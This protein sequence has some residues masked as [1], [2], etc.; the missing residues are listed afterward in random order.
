ML[1]RS[2]KGT[3]TLLSSCLPPADP[4][5]IR[6]PDLPAPGEGVQLYSP[7]WTIPAKGEGEVC[8][9]SYY[10]FSAQVPA[11]LQFDCPDR[12]GGSARKCFAY[13]RI[14]LTQDP[15]SHHSILRLY[16]GAYPI[17]DP[18]FG[19]FTCHGG[20]QD[21]MACNPTGIGV[22]APAGADCGPRSGCAG[23]VVPAVACIGYGP[24]DLS[25]GASI[26]GADS[27]KAPQIL[28]STSP[29]YRSVYPD[30]VY[31][32]MPVAGIFVENS[33]A[34][35]TTTEQIGRASCRERV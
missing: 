29:F 2:V 30:G 32:V 23:T 15:N 11:E 1:F 25:E 9:P 7:P 12:W 4:Q 20:D 33:H 5:K 17:T 6:P 14:E 8:V 13:K 34:F 18:S 10:D 27:R 21:G 28:I 31:N 3:D 19:T 26:I 22:A 35:N 24:P 16:R